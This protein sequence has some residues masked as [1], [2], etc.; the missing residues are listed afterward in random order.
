MQQTHKAQRVEI[1]GMRLL[2]MVFGRITA[3][4]MVENMPVVVGVVTE[5]TTS[6]GVLHELRERLA[7]REQRVQLA[8]L[9]YRVDDVAEHGRY[10]AVGLHVDRKF[11][12]GQHLAAAHLHGSNLQNV[13]LEDVQT[14][15][16]G[17]EHH[18]GLRLVAAH[19]TLQVGLAEALALLVAAQQVGRQNGVVEQRAH[20]VARR[21]VGLVHAHALHQSRP[22]QEAELVVEHAEVGKQQLQF[23]RREEVRTRHLEV[24][25]AEAREFAADILGVAVS[26]HDECRGRLGKHRAQSAGKLHTVAHLLFV[27][28]AVEQSE[29]VA[30]RLLMRLQSHIWQQRRVYLQ[31]FCGEGVENVEQILRRAV[32]HREVVQVARSLLLERR[33][34]VYLCAHEREYGLLLV[35]EEH[36]RAVGARGE[37]LDDSQ[38]QL[39][40]VLHLVY[41]HPCVALV[42]GL[43]GVGVQRVVG[44]QK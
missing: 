21:S 32:V 31:F 14:R 36:H 19:E 37:Q 10:L 17:V 39:V 33:E 28:L 25:D 42:E 5:Q 9:Y 34:R 15:R 8:L 40:E 11:G 7:V 35:A 27:C 44:E 12:V 41:L 6:F 29:L 43:F 1:V 18:D 38:L 2:E 16:L 13:V 3:Q 22:R 24:S 26:V 20:E 23:G 30:E 4:V